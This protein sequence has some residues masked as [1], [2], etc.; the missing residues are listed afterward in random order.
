MR[1]NKRDYAADVGYYA[2]TIHR[3]LRTTATLLQEG[4]AEKKKDVSSVTSSSSSEE[5]SAGCLSR[6]YDLTLA[7]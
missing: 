3:K 7:A 5:I 6:L 2:C 4:P 1:V